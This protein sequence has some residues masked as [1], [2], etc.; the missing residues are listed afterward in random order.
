MRLS[1]SLGLVF[2]YLQFFYW[3]RT[4]DNLAQYVDLIV[5]TMSDIKHFMVVLLVILMAF[6]SGFYMI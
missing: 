5:E 2:M 4:F 3:L 6:Y 1:A